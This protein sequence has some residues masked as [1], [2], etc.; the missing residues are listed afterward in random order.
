MGQR[1][2]VPARSVSCQPPKEGLDRATTSGSKERD[3]LSNYRRRLSRV[4]SARA[5]TGKPGKTAEYRCTRRAEAEGE[6]MSDCDA[7]LRASHAT[8]LE[9]V[10]GRARDPRHL[11]PMM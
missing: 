1:D 9:T 11:Q 7:S 4:K 2:N 5:D 3:L 10:F 8:G 6:E